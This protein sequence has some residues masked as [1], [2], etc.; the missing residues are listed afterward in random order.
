MPKFKVRGESKAIDLNDNNFVTKGGEGSIYIIGNTVYKVCLPDR[1]IEEKKFQELLVLKHPRIVIPENILLDT[2]NR[3]VGYTMRCVPNN[4]KPLVAILSKDYRERNAISHDMM[5]DLVK[6]MMDGIRFIHKHPGY[7]QVDG[8]EF[9]YMVTG[10]HKEAYFIDVNSFQTPNF[11]ADALMLSVRDWS[12]QQDPATQQFHWSHLS[13]WYSFAIVSWYMFTGIH[14]FKGKHPAFP[15]KK[16]FMTDQM[17][18]G[19]SIL[20]PGCQFPKGAVYYPFESVIP[21][22]KDGAFFRWY[23]AIFVDKKRLAPPT[24]FQAPAVYVAKVKEIIGS[25]KF[26]I[27]EINRYVDQIIAF[28][29]AKGNEVVVTENNLIV[30]NQV[31]PRDPGPVWI[32]FTE[33]SAIPVAVRKDG[34]YLKLENLQSKL[35]IHSMLFVVDEITSSDGHLYLRTGGTISRVTFMETPDSSLIA[36]LHK[37]ASVLP[38]GTLF[39]QGCAFQNIFGSMYASLFTGPL[40]H[41]V[42]IPEL[43]AIKIVEAKH[44]QNVLVV[45]GH[46][47]L[48]DQYNRYVFRFNLDR[49]AY[50]I[51]TVEN[52]TPIGVNF[53]VLDSGV[54]VLLTEE[55]KI[56]IFSNRKD[57]ASM[58]VIDDPV[59]KSNMRLCRANNQVRFTYGDK[60]FSISVRK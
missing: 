30:N 17:K 19:V 36:S 47:R 14:P 58:N 29:E 50:D 11:P 2:K 60:L 31:R 51:R 7:L 49:S 40:H 42:K 33:Q 44:E 10:D 8:N 56:E 41:Q 59:I 1:M 28:Y 57:A 39:F 37:V 16:T 15:D 25:N 46:D 34:D 18:A 23:E 43:D 53:T 13:D 38:K 26:E 22:G 12:V 27:K 21:G 52:V 32:C 6:Q 48:E 5:A 54:C 20:D 35:P 9:N 55:E 24:D 45:I 4:P 3:S